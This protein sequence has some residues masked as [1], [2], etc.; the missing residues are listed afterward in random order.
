MDVEWESG[1]TPVELPW[2]FTSFVPFF[3]SNPSLSLN[4]LEQGEIQTS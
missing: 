1:Q 3:L 4:T 2:N